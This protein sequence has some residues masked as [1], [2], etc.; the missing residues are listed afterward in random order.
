MESDF[1]DQYTYLRKFL[2]A[3]SEDTELRDLARLF[4]QLVANHGGPKSN[5]LSF[6]DNFIKSWPFFYWH[7]QP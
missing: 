2:M 3:A 7:T 6:C 4:Y 1:K 5:P